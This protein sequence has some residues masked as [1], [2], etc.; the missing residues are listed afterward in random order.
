MRE[1]EQVLANNL[2]L[3]FQESPEA[4]FAVDENGRFIFANSKWQ[5]LLGYDFKELNSCGKKLF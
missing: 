3:M 5:E 2:Q 4:I 1:E